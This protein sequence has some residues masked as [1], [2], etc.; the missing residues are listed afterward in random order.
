MSAAQR[1]GFPQ[2]EGPPSARAAV[3]KALAHLAKE[4]DV[5][6]VLRGYRSN[7]DALRRRGLPDERIAEQLAIALD[8]SKESILGFLK[9]DR[10]T[11]VRDVPS[12]G[13]TEGNTRPSYFFDS[14][15]STAAPA[16]GAEPPDRRRAPVPA[17][18]IRTAVET[19]MSERNIK[20]LRLSDEKI[21]RAVT[22]RVPSLHDLPKHERN[23]KIIDACA[24]R[25]HGPVLRSIDGRR[26]IIL[27][28]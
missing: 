3:E 25:K 27:A 1:L 11:G 5:L 28:P 24:G 26:E 20:S 19:V 13:Q 6:N 12:K 9:S 23:R 15:A 7:I 14:D 8:T 21:V 22:E 2:N 10:A 17:A 18:E 4:V 16:A